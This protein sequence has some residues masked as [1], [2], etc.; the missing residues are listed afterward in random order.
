MKYIRWIYKFV[1][2]HAGAMTVMMLCHVLLAACAVGFVYV[3][4]ALVDVAVAQMQGTEAGSLWALGS[5]MVCIV[6]LRIALN[7]LRNYLQTR[8]EIRLKNSLRRKLFDILLRTQSDGGSQKHTG[9]VLNRLQEDVRQVSNVCAASLPNVFGTLLQFTAAFVF[10]MML[11]PMLG[12]IILVIAPLGIFLGR[13]VTRRVRKLTHDIRDSDA[14]VQSHL[15]ESVQHVT[16]LQSME[17]ADASASALGELQSGLYGSE[18]RRAKFSVIS[19]IFMMLAFQAGHTVAFLWAVFGISKGTVTYGMMTAFLQL[20][21][22]MQRPLVELSSQLPAVIHATA[23][24]DRIAEIEQLPREED[25]D[26]CM[27]PATAGVRFDGVTFGYPG[28]ASVVLQDF[29]HDFKPGSRTAIVGPTG[30]GKST[31]IRLLLSLLRPQSGEITVYSDAGQVSAPASPATRCNL[32]YVPQ[33]NSLFSGSV[34]DNLLMGNPDATE[35]ELRD[36]LHIAAADFVFDLKDGLDAQCFEA[37]RGLSEGQAQRI[38]IA[39]A[40]LRPG[41]ILLLDEFSS[42]LDA[43]TEITLMQRLTASLPDHTM[44]FITHR[45]RI[46]DYCD[47]V[48]RLG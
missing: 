9:D 33:G 43:E 31:M 12:L 36:A 38:A 26:P 34:R 47:S 30:V 37:G 45:E 15:Q 48:L 16:L 20:V 14:K 44:I 5:F 3:S 2:P 7:A 10:L 21:G 28:S 22:Q 8:T 27:M 1:R 19:R 39:R 24:I 6:L 32:V 25:V 4:K 46:I 18:L 17:H 35:Q 13:Y 41:S 23:S 42:A 11:E 40:L 29:S